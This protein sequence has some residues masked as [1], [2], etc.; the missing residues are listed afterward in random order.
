MQIVNV[1]YSLII[2]YNF[3][4]KCLCKLC[5]LSRNKAFQ[6]RGKCYYICTKAHF[7]IFKRHGRIWWQNGP[8]L[9]N[10]TK[11]TGDEFIW[12]IRP[13]AIPPRNKDVQPVNYRERD[14]HRECTEDMFATDSA[15]FYKDQNIHATQPRTA[16][17]SW[18]TCQLP[19]LVA[20]AQQKHFIGGQQCVVIFYFWIS[21]YVTF[22][23]ADDLTQPGVIFYPLKSIL[24]NSK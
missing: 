12:R 9:F 4:C 3:I 19:F 13:N 22:D 7:I 21:Q 1:N 14:K 11:V 24:N 10:V 16:H 6:I 5:L 20:T 18:F 8:T 2:Y 23:K 15:M 17:I